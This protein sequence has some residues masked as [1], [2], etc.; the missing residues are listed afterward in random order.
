MGRHGATL[1]VA[2]E[3][4]EMRSFKL[5][6]VHALDEIEV[7][8]TALADRA[9]EEERHALHTHVKKTQYGVEPRKL[10]RT[11]EQQEM[12]RMVEH[13]RHWQE[14]QSMSISA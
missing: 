12:G 3:Y 10:D 8:V 13:M 14:I 4:D 6:N 2:S 9:F 7:V 1:A 5:L 11:R